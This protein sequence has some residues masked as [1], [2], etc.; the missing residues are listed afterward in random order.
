MAGRV[1]ILSR[2]DASVVYSENSGGGRT[3]R[4]IKLR[5]RSKIMRE[6]KF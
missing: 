6:V 1:E 4:K 5:K 3:R 2:V